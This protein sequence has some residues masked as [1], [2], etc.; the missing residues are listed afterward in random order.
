MLFIQVVWGKIRVREDRQEA[1]MSQDV[2]VRLLLETT[3]QYDP[4]IDID[5]AT[6]KKTSE[7]RARAADASGVGASED[8]R[9][10]TWEDNI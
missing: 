8:R 9:I 2:Y 5:I 4:F 10:H 6:G 7:C 3:D 1:G